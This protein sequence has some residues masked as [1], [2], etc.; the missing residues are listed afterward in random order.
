[1]ITTKKM[2]NR[3]VKIV[4]VRSEQNDADL[5]TKNLKEDT[6]VRHSEKFMKHMST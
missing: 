6:Y 1:M 3:T 2:E 4:F 5:W